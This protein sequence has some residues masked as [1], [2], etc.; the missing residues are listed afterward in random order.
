MNNAEKTKI[1]L[2]F[3]EQRKQ[4]LKIVSLLVVGIIAVAVSTRFLLPGGKKISKTAELPE[5]KFTPAWVESCPS[6]HCS[7]RFIIKL[8]VSP[9]LPPKEY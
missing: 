3:Q 7:H 4:D 9:T 6:D 5:E 8:P 1:E 2:S